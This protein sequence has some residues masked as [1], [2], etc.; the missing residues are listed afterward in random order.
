MLIL[1]STVDIQVTFPEMLAMRF[2]VMVVIMVVKVGGCT[3]T[4]TN[5]TM[6]IKGQAMAVIPLA[7]LK[8]DGTVVEVLPVLRMS[9]GQL[10]EIGVIG[11]VSTVMMET[12]EMEMVAVQSVLKRLA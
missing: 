6:E 9:A 10:V 5:V 12:I 8:K 4:Q 2:A 1:I 11:I 3:E 7:V